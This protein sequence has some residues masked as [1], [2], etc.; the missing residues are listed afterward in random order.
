MHTCL[1]ESHHLEFVCT[2]LHR[3]VLAMMNWWQCSNSRDESGMWTRRMH[4]LKRC[5]QLVSTGQSR[6]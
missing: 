6:Y 5:A 4:F 1:Q 2:R 3:Q